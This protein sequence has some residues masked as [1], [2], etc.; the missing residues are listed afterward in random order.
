[1]CMVAIREREAPEIGYKVLLRNQRTKVLYSQFFGNAKSLTT[2]VTLKEEDFAEHREPKFQEI[3]TVP[4]FKYGESKPYKRGWHVLET[5]ADAKK[6]LDTLT[7]LY[8]H[9]SV[10][11]KVLIKKPYCTGLEEIY[12]GEEDNEEVPVVVCGEIIILHQV[13]PWPH[14]Q[15]VVRE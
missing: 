3:R 14:L 5:L 6:L 13:Y 4:S 1:M 11:Y 2:G 8:Y 7:P 12:K 15:D 9:E 10:I